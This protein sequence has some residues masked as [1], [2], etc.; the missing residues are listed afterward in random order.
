MFPDVACL[1]VVEVRQVP[2][3]VTTEYSTTSKSLEPLFI[4]SPVGQRFRLKRRK[5]R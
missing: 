5:N 3:E 2:D 4:T 1:S